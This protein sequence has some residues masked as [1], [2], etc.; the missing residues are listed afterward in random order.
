MWM[1]PALPVSDK[2]SKLT[3][4]QSGALSF[5]FFSGREEPG[6]RADAVRC[7]FRGAFLR[8][9]ASVGELRAVEGLGRER[10]RA[11]D[12]C[13]AQRAGLR[14]CASPGPLDSWQ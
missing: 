2:G 9:M 13:N 5:R 7:I 14:M 10:T 6:D 11:V 3:F 4:F 8:T 12:S 1:L